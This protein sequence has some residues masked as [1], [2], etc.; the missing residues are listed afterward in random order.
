MALPIPLRIAIQGERGAYSQEAAVQLLGESIKIIATRDSPHMF[1]SV[2]RHRAHA[3]LAPME[4]SLVGSIYPHYDLMLR[5]GF[6]VLGEVYLKVEHCLIAPVGTYVEEVR[7][8][9]SHPVALE[10]CQEFFR[11]HP[12]M[13]AVVTYDTAGSVQM[14]IQSREA[15]GAAIAG[16]G[17]AEQYGGRVL[18]EHLED[19]PANY[20]RF[21]LL[22]HDQDRELEGVSEHF[23]RGQAGAPKTSVVFYVDNRPGALQGALGAFSDRGVDLTRIESR[24]IRGKPFEYL[25]YLDFH[26]DPATAPAAEAMDDLR[27][28]AGFLRNLGTYPAGRLD[29]VG[30]DEPFLPRP[31]RP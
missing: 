19:D 13:E 21:F 8:V 11:R 23:R 14:L 27:R 10:Q 9:Y 5:F 22:A 26:G 24:P 28:R 7:R 15:G 16:R 31:P 3:C 20:T 29:W 18:E 25:F 2:V 12:E 1:S 17:A 4:N 6:R 30:G